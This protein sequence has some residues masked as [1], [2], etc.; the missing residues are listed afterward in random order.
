MERSRGGVCPTGGLFPIA[1][2]CAAASWFK[3]THPTGRRLA[4]ASAIGVGLWNRRHI[5]HRPF[6]TESFVLP[7]KTGGTS[8]ASPNCT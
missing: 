3:L 4:I 1:F 2:R 5:R 6:V 7:P 8:H